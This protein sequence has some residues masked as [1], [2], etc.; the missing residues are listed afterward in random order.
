MEIVWLLN[1]VGSVMELLLL[2]AVVPFRFGFR[3]HG[4]GATHTRTKATIDRC[5]ERAEESVLYFHRKEFVYFFEWMKVSF[6]PHWLKVAPVAGI[7]SSNNRIF[8]VQIKTN[9]T[10]KTVWQF[11]IQREKGRTYTRSKT[12]DLF[13]HLTL[14]HSHSRSHSHSQINSQHCINCKG[15]L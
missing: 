7:L 9:W 13:G 2:T 1:D 8:A 14:S 6:A 11:A 15:L 3:F 4:L 5:R 12:S 10:K